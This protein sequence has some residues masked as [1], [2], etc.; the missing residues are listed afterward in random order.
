M[1]SNGLDFYTYDANGNVI[2]VTGADNAT[3]TYDALNRRVQVSPS[4]SD[5]LEFIY[6]LNGQRVSI[7]DGTTGS[8]IQ[9]QAY[10]GTMPVEFYENGTAHFQFQDWQGTERVQTSYNGAVEGTY[11][12]LPYG[13]G[14]SASGA[15]DDAY[16]YAMLDQDN[17][18]DEHA[19][20]REY[21]NLAGRWMSPD[22]Y[23]GSYNI[24]NPQSFNRYSYV[25]NQPLS[26]VDF[27]GQDFMVCGADGC[28]FYTDSVYE[29]TMSNGPGSGM[30]IG[31]DGTVYCG[32]T[33]CGSVTYLPGAPP[34]NAPSSPGAGYGRGGAGGSGS[35][36]SA[37]NNTPTIFSC[38]FTGKVG[39]SLG[40]TLL[41]GIGIIPGANDVVHGVQLGAT[42]VSTGIAVF[43][44][45]YG[46]GF[47][48]TG[49]GLTLAEKSLSSPETISILETGGKAVA[50]DGFE[51]IPV[52]GNIVSGIA[53]I[54][55]L[56]GVAAAYR[57]CLAGGS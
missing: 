31:P 32:D 5:S 48:A 35:S 34:P 57:T 30:S 38:T 25:M 50:K 18:S 15:D 10:W 19:I 36:S 37:Q 3:Y 14:Y 28:Y 39:M 21:S 22:R 33:A 1:T 12:S 47:T 7:W 43:G 55:D 17:S 11:N 6:N 54:H 9:G 2:S 49:T 27:T 56:F 44:D 4:G 40:E 29:E 45:A 16:H 52:A 8:Q 51:M 42:V 24:Y 46:A 13:D 23:A 53:T 20:F 26:Y 41:D